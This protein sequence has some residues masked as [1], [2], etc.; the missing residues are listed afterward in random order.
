MV[1]D[2]YEYEDLF[3]L[4]L[5]ND[6]IIGMPPVNDS[7]G[8]GLVD[9][10]SQY[11]IFNN[12]GGIYLNNKKG[13]K[14]SDTSSPLWDVVKIVESDSGFNALLAGSGKKQGKYRVWF[15]NTDGVINGQT[16][17]RNEDQI[18]KDGYEDVFGITLNGTP[19]K[20]TTPLTPLIPQN[21]LLHNDAS[22][23]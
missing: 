8:D 16:K 2:G 11:Q 18:A 15:T 7:D 9:G 22:I 23:F 10:S 5:N 1:K 21:P 17:W 12:K 20:G 14:F 13:R 19:V 3:G 4:D 6:Q